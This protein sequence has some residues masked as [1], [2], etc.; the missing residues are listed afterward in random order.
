MHYLK[1]FKKHLSSSDYAGVLSLWEEYC[2]GDEIESDEF[3]KILEEI[4]N[5]N[6]AEPFGKYVE[7]GL[8]LWEIIEKDETAHEIFK[9]IIDLQTTNNPKL[10]E[11]VLDY[12]YEKFGEDAKTLQ[13]LKLVGLRD[14]R[15]FQCA[16]ANFE[17]S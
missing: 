15:N 16:V 2:E 9:L 3:R 4:K 13:K 11:E 10:G 8:K 7:S 12:L 5:T 14:M 1:Q 17:L 6:F